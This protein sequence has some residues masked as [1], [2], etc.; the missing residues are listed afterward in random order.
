MSDRTLFWS[1]QI[2]KTESLQ[3]WISFILVQSRRDLLCIV[4]S[5]AVRYAF[6]DESSM[7]ECVSIL[8]CGCHHIIFL[9]SELI[10]LQH[11]NSQSL[12][13]IMNSIVYR[14][15]LPEEYNDAV[16]LFVGHRDDLSLELDS[17]VTPVF[18]V[19]QC[20]STTA[21][22]IGHGGYCHYMVVIFAFLGSKMIGALLGRRSGNHVEIVALC[23]RAVY[24]RQGVATRLFEQFVQ[25]VPND[26]IVLFISLF[27]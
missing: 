23:V 11:D 5:N 10:I 12:V 18:F 3:L 20:T 26:S 16:A 6:A 1:D 15:I 13:R 21:A 7:Q 9:R 8:A 19:L 25:R 2:F 27:P 22:P 14:T 17:L 4:G 24:R